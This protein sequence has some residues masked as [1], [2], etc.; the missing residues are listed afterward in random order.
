[1]KHHRPDT[2]THEAVALPR[3]DSAI[4]VGVTA[5]I[6]GLIVL[7]MAQAASSRTPPPAPAEDPAVST[8]LVR[9]E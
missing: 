2:K 8:T 7:W 4:V 5:A 3:R 9:G 6:V 1:M